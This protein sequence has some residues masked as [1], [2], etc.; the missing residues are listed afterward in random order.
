MRERQSE[1][2][3]CL[4]NPHNVVKANNTIRQVRAAPHHK[5][6]LLNMLEVANEEKIHAYQVMCIVYTNPLKDSSNKNL[7][8]TQLAKSQSSA[9]LLL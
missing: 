2:I 6:R 7:K 5:K 3:V 8:G 4:K 9:Y 1:T